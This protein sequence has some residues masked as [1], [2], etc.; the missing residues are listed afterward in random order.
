MMEMYHFCREERGTECEEYKEAVVNVIKWLINNTYSDKNSENL[1]N[2]ERALG[3]IFWDSDDKYVRTDSV[4]HA[5]NAY[6]GIIGD[7]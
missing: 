4:C 6:I 7:L 1:P 3:G 2:P 5:L